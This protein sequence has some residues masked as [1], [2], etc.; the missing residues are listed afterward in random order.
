MWL[1]PMSKHHVLLRGP[2]GSGYEVLNLK[3]CSIKRYKYC[4]N[5]LKGAYI[6]IYKL[7]R[8]LHTKIHIKIHKESIKNV[9]YIN[10]SV[11][12]SKYIFKISFKTM[13][14]TNFLS[15]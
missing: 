11:R 9:L 4:D 15:Q 3:A 14:S 6:P 8:E 1:R 13:K 2:V 12:S 7:I 5:I 10:I